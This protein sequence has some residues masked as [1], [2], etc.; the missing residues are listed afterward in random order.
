SD[1]YNAGAADLSVTGAQFDQYTLFRFDTSSAGHTLALP[2]AADIVNNL[3]SPYAGE[4]IY[5]AVAADGSNPVT[6]IAGTNVILKT[7]TSGVPE[8]STVTMYYEL[9]SITS[10]SEAVTIY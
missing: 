7:D 10:G 4:V 3:S 6:L 9:D 1:F 8:N 2:S 5:F